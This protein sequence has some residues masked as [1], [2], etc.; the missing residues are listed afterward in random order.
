MIMLHFSLIYRIANQLILQLLM[1]LMALHYV[2]IL[3]IRFT[4]N[5]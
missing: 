4:M 3:P 2:Q 5:Y 1:T